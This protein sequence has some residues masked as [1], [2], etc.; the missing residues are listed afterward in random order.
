MMQNEYEIPI[1]TGLKGKA[2]KATG[3]VEPLA[4]AIRLLRPQEVCRP[5]SDTYRFESEA[6]GRSLTRIYTK[7]E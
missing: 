4:L 3:A 5:G 6:I 1:S 2:L 7:A